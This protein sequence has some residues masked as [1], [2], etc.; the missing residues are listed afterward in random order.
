MRPTAIRSSSGTGSATSCSPCLPGRT[1]RASPARSRALRRACGRRWRRSSASPPASSSG[2]PWSGTPRS[3]FPSAGCSRCRGRRPPRAFRRMRAQGQGSPDRRQ[4]AALGARP[5]ARG[6]GGR[7]DPLA[8]GR[9]ARRR[10]TGDRAHAP[11]ARAR[12][13]D[14]GGAARRPVESGPQRSRGTIHMR[15]TLALLLVFVSVLPAA[16]E[17]RAQPKVDA[18]AVLRAL[19]DAFSAVADRV[20]PAVVNV[21]TV[22]KRSAAPE[23]PPERFREYFG[24]EFYERYFRQR[25]R[26]DARASGSGVIVDAKGY[27]LTNNHVIENA[28]DI[29]VRLTDG[30]KLGAKLVGRDPKTDLAVLKVDTPGPLPTAELGDSD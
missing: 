30:R 17:Q 4:G 25:P 27:I 23:E 8:G 15:T 3:S 24:E 20:T 26:E 1:A 22:P 21:T 6:R 16:A 19:E 5:R 28:Q 7:P 29:N 10:R 2:S 9:P 11:R 13:L 14:A 12:A 18:R